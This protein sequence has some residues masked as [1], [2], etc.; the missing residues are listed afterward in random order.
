MKADERKRKRSVDPGG[1]IQK[2]STCGTA[3]GAKQGSTKGN[4]QKAKYSESDGKHGKPGWKEEDKR[5]S[6]SGTEKLK[7]PAAR[8]KQWKRGKEEAEAE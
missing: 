1:E 5:G 3:V 2:G 4:E 7:R 6:E 8:R